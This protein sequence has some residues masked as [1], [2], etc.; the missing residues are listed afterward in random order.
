MDLGPAIPDSS[1]LK[2]VEIHPYYGCFRITI[3]LDDGVKDAPK[4][5]TEKPERIAAIDFGVNNLAAISNNVGLP[6]LLFKGG[7]VKAKINGLTSAE[8]LSFTA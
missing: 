2:Q 4:P 7:I 3:I 5:L 6:G 1:K 8:Q